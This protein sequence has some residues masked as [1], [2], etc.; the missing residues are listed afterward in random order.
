M[1][2]LFTDETLPKFAINWESTYIMSRFLAYGGNAPFAPFYVDDNNTVLSVLNGHAVLYTTQ[3]DAEEWTCFLAM[4][5]DITTVT[6]SWDIAKRLADALGQ[7]VQPKKIMRL[8][9]ALSTAATLVTEQTPRQVYPLLSTVFGNTMPAFE[10]WYVDVSHRLRHD[11][12]TIAGILW[13]NETVSTAMTVAQSTD[14]VV[15]GAVATAQ[16]ARKRGYAAQCIGYLAD[17]HKDKMIMISP[18]NPYAERLYT[19]MGFVVTDTIGQFY[20]RKED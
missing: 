8:Q 7:S 5:P 1:I 10:D 13:D 2:R 11:N 12:C 19:D 15:I 16:K 18:K 17:K 20:I 14:A 4:H 9:T 3:F 6:A